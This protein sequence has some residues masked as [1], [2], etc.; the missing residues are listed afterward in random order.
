MDTTGW[1]NIVSATAGV[2]F[3]PNP[4]SSLRFSYTW[5]QLYDKSDAWYGVGGAINAFGATLYRD[6]TG[7][8]GRDIGQELS[9]DY[10][11]TLDNGFT[12]SAGAGVFLPGRFV[13]SFGG[14][15]SGNQ[16]FGYLMLS[17]KF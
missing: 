3:K 4:S 11:A 16:T 8:S 6:P 12:L 14:S 10:S 15:R 9:L 13:K 2:K 17:W 5:L 1:K 7:N